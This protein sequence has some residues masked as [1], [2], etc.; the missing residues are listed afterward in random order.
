MNG[1]NVDEELENIVLDLLNK[2]L[3]VHTKMSHNSSKIYF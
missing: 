3:K 1:L 2:T